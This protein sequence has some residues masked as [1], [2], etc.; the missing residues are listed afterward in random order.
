MYIATGAVTG[1]W[2]NTF[3]KDGVHLLM[4]GTWSTIDRSN[5][6]LMDGANVYAGAVNDIVAIVV[7]P[8]DPTHA[9]AGSW[10][11]GLLE[12]RD[13]RPGADLQRRQQLAGQ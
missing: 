3:L 1:T 9:Y 13:G 10:D 11:D 5:S 2:C 7:D 6:P 12:L 8:E 4:D